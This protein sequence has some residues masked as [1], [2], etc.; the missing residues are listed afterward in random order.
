MR[1]ELVRRGL[2]GLAAAALIG[3]GTAGAVG[4]EEAV[5]DGTSY[6]N[7]DTGELLVVSPVPGYGT[8]LVLADGPAALIHESYIDE[9]AGDDIVVEFI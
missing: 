1:T 5:S 7:N 6:S 2:V 8:T 3:L 9:P 4:A